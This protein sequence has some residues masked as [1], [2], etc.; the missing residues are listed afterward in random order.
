M[1]ILVINNIQFTFPKNPKKLRFPVEGGVMSGSTPKLTS[2]CLR[3]LLRVTTG[4]SKSF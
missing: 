1:Y 4:E 2:L 3:P